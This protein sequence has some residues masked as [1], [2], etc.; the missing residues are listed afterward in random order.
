MPDGRRRSLRNLQRLR[1]TRVG[2]TCLPDRHLRNAPPAGGADLVLPDC[3]AGSYGVVRFDRG[4]WCPYC[5]PQRR[6][7]Q[8]AQADHAKAG[9]RVVS[10]S[11]DDEATTL[12]LISKHGLTV[13]VGHS[14]DHD[15]PPGEVPTQ[16][17]AGEDRR[18]ACRQDHLS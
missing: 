5:P 12:K 14:A 7:F 11:V 1:L 2:N 17:P 4:A 13:P 10:L 8:R 16:S 3:L 9:A 6:A 18:Q 15:H